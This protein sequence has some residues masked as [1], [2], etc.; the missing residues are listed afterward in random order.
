MTG[1]VTDAGGVVFALPPLTQW[2]IE[3]TDAE[4]CDSF[5]VQLP[6]DAL[7]GSRLQN[8]VGFFA[9]H[10][11]NRVMTGVVDELTLRLGKDGL[12][13]EL[14]GRS[15]A[16]KLLDTQVRAAE[17]RSAQLP[18]ILAH[19]VMPCGITSVDADELP[20]VGEFVVETGYSCYQVLAGFC[21]H[22][23]NVF[24]RF[25][26]DGTLILKRGGTGRQHVLAGGCIEAQYRFDRYSPAVKQVL[27]NTRNGEQMQAVNREFEALGG[28]GTQV[29]GM[30]G[31]K[32]RAVWRTAQQRLEDG[33]RNA[34][35]LSLTLPGSF[36]AEPTDAV[37]VTLPD[38]GISGNFTVRSVASSCD[39]SGALCKLEL[40]E[41]YVAI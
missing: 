2:Q 36:L 5:C 4:P 25:A 30:T 8:A 6:Y 39:D 16:A 31:Q 9:E 32:I 38:L 13:A 21:R 40:R 12:L 17:Y 29:N 41:D 23:A 26:A 1:Y 27:V 18:D 35:T 19:Y 14:S 24:V 34:R 28:S 11:G 37:L 3:R 15:L 22:S 20:Q 7:L 33:W 10:A